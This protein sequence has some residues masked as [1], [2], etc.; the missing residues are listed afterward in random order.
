M[1]SFQ[2]TVWLIRDS[3]SDMEDISDVTDVKLDL[4]VIVVRGDLSQCHPIWNGITL[5]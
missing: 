5:T 3:Q 2:V 4:F 1:S